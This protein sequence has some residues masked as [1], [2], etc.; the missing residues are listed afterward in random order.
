MLVIKLVK[1]EFRACGYGVNLSKNTI[2]RYITLGRVGT[3]PLTRG[4]EGMMPLHAFNLLML[5]VESYVQINQFNSV[6]VERHQ[7]LMTVNACCGVAP[8][9]CKTKHSVFDRVMKA[10]NVSLNAD[11]SP[12][13]YRISRGIRDT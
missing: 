10:T 9:E 5:T 4:Y 8:S 1:G 7:L 2:N 3:F 6:V 11:V 12:A 13:V